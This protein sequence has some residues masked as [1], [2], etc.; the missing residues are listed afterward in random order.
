MT[1]KVPK[2][3]YTAQFPALHD[4]LLPAI[5][6]L[7][8]AGSYVRGS[9]VTDFE[10]RLAGFL[11]VK[12]VV[13]VNSGTDALILA[14][15]ALDIGPG[16]EV[17]T[18]ANTWHSTALAIVRVGAKPVLVDCE[19]ESYLIDLDAAGNA[20]T[21]AT[22]A[23]IVVHLYGQCVDMDSALAL[24]EGNG[25]HLIE[26]CAQAIGARWAGNRVGSLGNVGCWSF[27]PAKNLSAA[28]DAGAVSTNDK[29]LA[30]KVS[31]LGNFGQQRQ[32]DHVLLGY[33]SRLDSIQAL[34]LD[35][36]LRHVDTWNAAR[37]R[38]AQVYRSALRHLPVRFQSGARP[39]GHVY[40][41]FQIRVAAAHRDLLLEYLISQG[42]DAVVRYP[43]P[44]HMQRAFRYLGIHPGSFPVAEALSRETLCLPIR[45]D[46]SED[47]IGYVT[48]AVSGFFRA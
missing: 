35:H 6:N 40:H 10:C 27:A 13:G 17:I 26:D 19:E 5:E 45:P 32:N 21:S 29:E 42:I 16:D 41:L 22:K 14:L 12:R 34:I 31:L 44:L 30:E 4:E 39:G 9:Q 2:Y 11:G 47:E 48:Q 33:N 43:V 7:V 36:K 25:L 15:K 1:F 38:I 18:V 24:C 28:G 37:V 23:V 3:N 8:T 46:L 20:I